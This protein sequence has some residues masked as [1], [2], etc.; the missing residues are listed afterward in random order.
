MKLLKFVVLYYGFGVAFAILMIL[1]CRYRAHVGLPSDLP[2]I[3]WLW[4]PMVVTGWPFMALACAVTGQAVT[5]TPFVVRAFGI[6][7][8]IA[9]VVALAWFLPRRPNPTE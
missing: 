5:L 3:S 8:L 7:F 1:Y 4:T 2:C 6:A 9:F